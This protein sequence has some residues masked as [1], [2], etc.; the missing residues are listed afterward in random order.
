MFNWLIFLLQSSKCDLN[1]TIISITLLLGILISVLSILPKI[2]ESK[3]VLST[4]IM[5]TSHF[6]PLFCKCILLPFL[7]ISGGCGLSVHYYLIIVCHVMYS[8]YVS[9]SIF[10]WSITHLGRIFHTQLMSNQPRCTKH[11][12]WRLRKYWKVCANGL[13]LNWK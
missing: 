13:C 5:I 7:Q 6:V 1:K 11:R 8:V 4:L 12:N 10:S 3:C 2:Q 9:L